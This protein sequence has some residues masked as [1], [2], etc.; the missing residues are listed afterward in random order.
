MLRPK[1]Q[2]ARLLAILVVLVLLGA[3]LLLLA[4]GKPRVGSE[5]FVDSSGQPSGDA[6]S[7]LQRARNHDDR[8]VPTPPKNTPSDSAPTPVAEAPA[9]PLVIRGRVVDAETDQPL[10]AFEILCTPAGAE[11]PRVDTMLGPES[12]AESAFAG[13]SG[14]FAVTVLDVEERSVCAFAL[15]Y[16]RS[17]PV[18]ATPGSELEI[19]LG[20]AAIVRGQVVD[21]STGNP[22]EGALVGWIDRQGQPRTGPLERFVRTDALGRFELGS[23]PF[24]ARG[25]IAGREDLGEGMSER[26]DLAPDDS[27]REVVIRL[28]RTGG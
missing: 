26:L 9:V 1:N 7:E 25:V 18:T 16:E 2:D 10:D 15:G 21:P 13:S 23:V 4:R 19:R 17:E 14:R 11:Q 22:V 24:S 27:E 20:R 6:A 8:S 28:R 5:T 3:G 12:P